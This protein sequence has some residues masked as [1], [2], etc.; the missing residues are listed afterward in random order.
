VKSQENAAKF[1]NRPNN[2]T[3]H[4]KTVRRPQRS[5]AAPHT[6]AP[7]N[8]PKN[9]ALMSSPT[10]AKSIRRDVINTVMAAATVSVVNPSRK[11]PIP[12]QVAHR[13]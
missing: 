8:M 13:E 10:L 7:T 9:A 11:Q 2:P 6:M 4:A 1:D 3:L 5:L 12:T